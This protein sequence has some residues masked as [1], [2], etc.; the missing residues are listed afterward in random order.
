MDNQLPFVEKEA[1]WG[2]LSWTPYH[3]FLLLCREDREIIYKLP[4][5]GTAWDTEGEWKLKLFND[6]SFEEVLFYHDQIFYGRVFFN[7]VKDHIELN[8]S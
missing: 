6:F 2:R 7:V 5:V 8:V 4:S 3:F 1:I